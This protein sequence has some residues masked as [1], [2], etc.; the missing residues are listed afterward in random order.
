M[1]SVWG[2]D[3]GGAHGRSVDIVS[4]MASFGKHSGYPYTWFLGVGAWL[5][6]LA[7]LA[8]VGWLG[9]SNGWLWVIL[10]L[11]GILTVV[12]GFVERGRGAPRR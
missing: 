9:R 12:L 5:M 1:P 3:A 6:I 11:A 10:L 2:C 8:F 4:R 7:V